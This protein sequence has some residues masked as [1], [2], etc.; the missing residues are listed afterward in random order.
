[1]VGLQVESTHW[2]L[3]TMLMQGLWSSVWTSRY[4]KHLYTITTHE[5]TS[6]GRICTVASHGT[7]RKTSLPDVGVRNY[8][9]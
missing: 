6:V 3:V 8:L 2:I 7:D 5:S 1:M 4:L 9:N